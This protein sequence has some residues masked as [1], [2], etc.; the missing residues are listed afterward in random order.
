MKGTKTLIFLDVDGV[1]NVSCKD[2]GRGALTLGVVNVRM[3]Q[4]VRDRSHPKPGLDTAER[5]LAVN[6]CELCDGEEGTFSRFTSG[7]SELCDKLVARLSWLIAATGDCQV[8]L[9]STWRMPQ[10]LRKVRCLEEEISRHIRRR[11]V[12]D[13]RTELCADNSAVKRMTNIGNYLATQPFHRTHRSVRALILDDLGTTPFGDWSLDGEVVTC[14][15][16]AEAYLAKR[17]ALAKEDVC[18]VHTYKQF[19]TSAG[20]QVQMG[21]GLTGPHMWSA[22]AFLGVVWNDPSTRETTIA[23][24]ELPSVK[25]TCAHKSFARKWAARFLMA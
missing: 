22:A 13:E 23:R 17:G 5:V 25:R 20:L 15:G 1:L 19:T 18:F 9:S 21:T 6:S 2:P 8:V 10:H 24:S 16:V 11:F 3:A 7:E 12:L 4:Q 14:P